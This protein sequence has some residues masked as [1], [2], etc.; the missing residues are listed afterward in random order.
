MEDDEGNDAL[1]L[2]FEFYNGSDEAETFAM[3][4]FY[5]VYQDDDELDAAYIYFDP[6]SYDTLE[7]SAWE[8]VDP[9]DS[10]YVFL[11]Y[12]L[13]DLDTDVEIE[14]SDMMDEEFDY[15]TV[16]LGDAEE[17]LTEYYY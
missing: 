10:K 15:L 14:F 11:T 6:D 4:Y 3:A 16:D 9:G 17:G 12:V 7:D 13:K 5:E 8:E 1:V 2:A